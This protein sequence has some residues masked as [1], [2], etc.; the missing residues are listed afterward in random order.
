MLAVGMPAYV[1]PGDPLF[2]LLTDPAVEPPELV[3]LNLDHGDGD[4]R[5]LDPVADAL[6]ART[7][8]TGRP[9]RVLGYVWTSDLT[10]RD[11][12]GVYDFSNRPEAD[13]RASVDGW[14]VRADGAVHYDG[15]FFDVASP[16][17]E[18]RDKFLRL[19]DH[20]RRRSPSALIVH[21][22]GVAVAAAYLE[23]GK[24]T[25]DIFAT[26]EGGVDVYD[27]GA[28]PPGAP[29]DYGYWLGGNVSDGGTYVLG[30]RLTFS[31]G[32]DT[33]G[34]PETVT[35]DPGSFWHLVYEATAEHTPA[36]AELARSRHAGVI[37]V[38]TAPGPPA[39]PWVL[40]PG[41][42]D[43]LAVLLRCAR[44]AVGTAAP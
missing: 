15:I 27:T 33:G 35:V 7:T 23:P 9:V 17:A 2:T 30:D 22:A 32:G 13:I 11:A 26:F 5:P 43:H 36:I 14:L 20:V 8:A 44:G 19:R 38:S 39:N 25:A 29:V 21:N 6:R 40:G 12:G 4:M 28:P 24:R 37:T 34:R 41:G 10:R 18:H 42:A 31:R 3:V 16:V 1:R